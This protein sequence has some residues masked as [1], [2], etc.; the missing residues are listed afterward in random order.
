MHRTRSQHT[1]NLVRMRK[2]ALLLAV[3]ATVALAQ[4]AIT[5]VPGNRRELP[6]TVVG[7]AGA[8]LA[9]GKYV[10]RVTGADSRIC[11]AEA[12]PDGGT[13]CGT[14]DGGLAGEM[15]PAGTVMLE[16]MPGTGRTVSCASA[17]DAGVMHFTGAQ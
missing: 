10:V 4:S 12:P 16:T 13:V 6:C 2:P 3:V 15:F 5:L 14:L 9:P 17:S 1:A 7:S 11:L 8:W